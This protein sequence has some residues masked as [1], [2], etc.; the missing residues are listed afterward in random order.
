LLKLLTRSGNR[1]Q[2]RQNKN[3]SRFHRSSHTP[4]LDYKDGLR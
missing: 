2:S 1:K 4:A 3:K